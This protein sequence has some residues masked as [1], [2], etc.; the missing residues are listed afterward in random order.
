MSEKNIGLENSKPNSELV[1]PLSFQLVCN[2]EKSA[3]ASQHTKTQ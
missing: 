3:R 2:G 1:C